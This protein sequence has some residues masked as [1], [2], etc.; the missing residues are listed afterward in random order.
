MLIDVQCTQQDIQQQGYHFQWSYDGSLT[1]IK[2][3]FATPTKNQVTPP[4]A[5][6][7]TI[8]IYGVCAI[9]SCD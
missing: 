9:G 3:P 5:A 4:I 7:I 8:V 6:H 1:N 2:T